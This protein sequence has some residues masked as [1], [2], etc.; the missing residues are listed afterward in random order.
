MRKKIII[1][2]CLS[3]TILTSVT[4]FAVSGNNKTI[5]TGKVSYYSLNKDGSTAARATTEFIPFNGYQHLRAYTFIESVNGNGTRLNSTQ[6][7]GSSG[8]TASKPATSAV[9]LTQAG[10][11][12]W[13]S[14]HRSE[15]TSQY[16][17]LALWN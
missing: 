11:S 6:N 16:A 1:G 14:T 15:K 12:K 4:A 13:G 7:Y 8:G 3:A 5:D 10:T 17:S 9:R 2:L